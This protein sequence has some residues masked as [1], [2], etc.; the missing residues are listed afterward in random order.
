MAGTGELNRLG[1]GMPARMVDT[2]PTAPPET[3]D[4]VEKDPD[5]WVTGEDFDP[6][7]SKADASKEIERLQTETGRG[8]HRE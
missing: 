3:L 1:P 6:T 8:R 7:L 5:V 2:D 4:G